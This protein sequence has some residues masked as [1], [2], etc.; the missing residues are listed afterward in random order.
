MQ[1]ANNHGYDTATGFYQAIN[2][3]HLDY[4]YETLQELGRGTF[5]QV[6]RCKD[7]KTGKQVA[8]KV[9]KNLNYAGI[10]NC[11]REVRLLE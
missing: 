7:H 4:R 5:G 9:S 6:L 3:D 10:E 11:M 2:G 1:F 8:I